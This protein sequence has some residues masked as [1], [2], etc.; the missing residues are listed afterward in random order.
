MVVGYLSAQD[1][2]WQMDLLRRVTQGRLSEIFGEKLVDT[3]VLLRKLRMPEHSEKL[4]KTLDEQVTNP[5]RDFAAGINAYIDQQ[6]D[7][8]PFEFKLLGY[9]PEKWQA[10]QS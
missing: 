9:Q 10:Q 1:R 6:K 5:L 8:L 3:D 4:Y 7:D 2:L